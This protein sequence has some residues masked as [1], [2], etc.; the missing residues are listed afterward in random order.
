MMRHGIVFLSIILIIAIFP[1][2]EFV[3]FAKADSTVVLYNIESNK[4]L[5]PSNGSAD[6]GAPIVQEPCNK[7]IAQQWTQISLGN[8]DSTM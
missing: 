7:S 6:Q 5:Q 8:N 4:C 2:P 1:V 3:P